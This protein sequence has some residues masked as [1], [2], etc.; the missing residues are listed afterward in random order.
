LLGSANPNAVAIERLLQTAAQLHRHIPLFNRQRFDPNPNHHPLVRELIHPKKLTG[1]ENLTASGRVTGHFFGSI[2]HDRQSQIH[3]GKSD[4]MRAYP[5][6][7]GG[8][9]PPTLIQQYSNCCPSRIG[10][11]SIHLPNTK[12]EL[13]NPDLT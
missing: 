6:D 2:L 13:A 4:S 12:S 1:I 8:R 11:F 5:N 9:C 7:S 10:Q 3:I